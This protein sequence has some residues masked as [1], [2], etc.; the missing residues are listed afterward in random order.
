[1]RF[2]SLIAAVL[3][4]VIAYGA[5][6]AG[7]CNAIC[8]GV[9]ASEGATLGTHHAVNRP[10][11]TR[12][13]HAAAPSRAARPGSLPCAS[14]VASARDCQNLARAAA[15]ESPSKLRLLHSIN[16]ISV[17]AVQRPLASSPVRQELHDTGP[18]RASNPSAISL[19]I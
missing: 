9:P 5:S 6:P 17:P 4:V 10:V 2:H 12:H 19:R 18:P 16:V 7:V 14:A 3:A 1:M 11:P 8:G 15:I 13:Q